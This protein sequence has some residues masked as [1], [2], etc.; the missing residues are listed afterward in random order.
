[1]DSIAKINAILK[2]R[3]LSGADL[4]TMIGVS[5]SVYSQWNTRKTKPSSKSLRKVAEVLDVPLSDLLEDE[6]PVSAAFHDAELTQEE[7]DELWMRAREFYNFIRQQKLKEK[8]N[9]K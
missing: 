7:E 3:G 6:E 1:M 4:E 8:Q 5:N 2:R 9:K